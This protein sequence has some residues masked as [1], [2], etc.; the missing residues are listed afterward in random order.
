M[1]SPH[2]RHDLDGFVKTTGLNDESLLLQTFMPLTDKYFG[3]L[4]DVYM[5]WIQHSAGE[6]TTLRTLLQRDTE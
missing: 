5:L 3:K 2:E 4:W 1:V 6:E